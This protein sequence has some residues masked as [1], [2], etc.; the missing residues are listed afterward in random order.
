MTGYICIFR[1]MESL[2]SYETSVTIFNSKEE[3]IEYYGNNDDLI[4]DI[5]KINFHG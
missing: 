2:S 1:P 5:I 3:A 4:V